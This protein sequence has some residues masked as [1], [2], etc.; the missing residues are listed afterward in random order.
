MSSGLDPPTASERAT[1]TVNN[2][3]HDDHSTSDNA[4]HDGRRPQMPCLPGN[5]YSS[6]ACSTAHA[7]TYVATLPLHPVHSLVTTHQTRAIVHTN[8]NTVEINSQEGTPVSTCLFRPFTATP[9]TSSH[10]ISTNATPA[11]NLFPTQPLAIAE[12]ARP[13]HLARPPPSR[14]AI[15]VSS[16]VSHVTVP[17]RAVRNPHSLSLSIAHNSPFLFVL[18]PCPD[19]R[20][21]QQ[22]ASPASVVARMSNFTGKPLQAVPVTILLGPPPPPHPRSALALHG[23]PLITMISSSRHRRPRHLLPP[24]PVRTRSSIPR[25]P[26]TRPPLLT[27]KIGRLQT[28]HNCPFPS[29][30]MRRWMRNTVHRSN[31]FGVLVLP[32]FPTTLRRRCSRVCIPSSNTNHHQIIGTLPGVNLELTPLWMI[33]SNSRA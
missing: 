3:H 11:K 9:A 2:V 16:P 19:P 22:N 17:T 20:I 25:L 32:Y 24:S 21:P 12:R 29:R 7:I 10:A 28:Y 31:S 15:N 23:Y 18:S 13:P 27:L 1:L 26:S 6:S 8:A 14:L 30:L 5:F 33:P 4:T